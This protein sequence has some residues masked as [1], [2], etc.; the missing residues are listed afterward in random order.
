M[1][2]DRGQTHFTPAEIDDLRQQLADFKAA[3]GYGW[4]RV[5][6][7]TGVAAGTLSGWVPGT[8]NGG[9]IHETHAITAK[10]QKFFLH[11]ESQRQLDR[12]VAIVPAYQPTKTARRIHACLTFAQR[13][14]IAA[15]VGDP[16]VGKTAA[17]AQYAATGTNVWQVTMSP[18]T[19][20]LNAALLALMRAMG[21]R[22]LGGAS[23]AI[24]VMIRDKV[25]GRGG[26]FLIDEAQHLSERALEEIRAIHDDTGVGV[27]L[28][29]NREV[30]T[31]IEG[32]GRT[33]AF[34]QLFSRVS[35]RMVIPA[36]DLAD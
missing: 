34:A 11:Q 28:T 1:N 31:R 2:I 16:G 3:N 23:E 26:L 29:G 18:S 25:A 24:S 6:Q 9:K 36:P 27:A 32:A 22:R 14:K 33:A 35:I 4:Q 19:A 21:A 20:S 30:L 10:V 7:L 13:G 8:Y 17:L 12:E 5:A 15:I